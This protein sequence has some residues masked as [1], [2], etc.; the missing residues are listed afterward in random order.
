MCGS[1]R[2]RGGVAAEGARP[3][4]LAADAALVALRR[5]SRRASVWTRPPI[6]EKRGGSCC[7]GRLCGGRTRGARMTR[8]NYVGGRWVEAKQGGGLPVINPATEETIDH[9]AASTLEDV[10]AAVQAAADA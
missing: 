3:C 7:A 5:S 4:R 10:D 9:V 2:R 8:S 1:R 6:R